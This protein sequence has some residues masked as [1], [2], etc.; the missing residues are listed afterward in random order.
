MTC[1]TLTSCTLHNAATSMHKGKIL[2]LLLMSICQCAQTLLCCMPRLLRQSITGDLCDA[3]ETHHWCAGVPLLQLLHQ[4]EYASPASHCQNLVCSPVDN[5]FYAAHFCLGA[6]AV[7]HSQ[8]ESLVTLHF[9]ILHYAGVA[10]CCNYHV[11][12]GGI[13]SA[14]HPCRRETIGML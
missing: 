5:R 3:D 13:S 14:H 7:P 11:S 2:T 9:V 8:G 10:A 6:A 1:P 12:V 4:A